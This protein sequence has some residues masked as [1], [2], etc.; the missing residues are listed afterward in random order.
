MSSDTGTG[1]HQ[2][3]GSAERATGEAPEPRRW[4]LPVLPGVLVVAL[5]E[6]CAHWFFPNFLP[7]P[8][9]IVLAAPNFVTDPT[10]S[11]EFFGSVAKTMLAVVE[12]IVIGV[13]LGVPAGLILG[14]NTVV[15]WFGE[16]YV[17]ALNAMPVVAIIPLSTLWLGYSNNMRLAVTAL[18][19]YLP[20]TLNVMDGTKHL[21]S[22]YLDVARS[23]RAGR[24][25]MWF[26]VA[27]P[28]ATPYLISGVQIAAGRAM[29]TG[30][31][32]EMIAAIQ[33]LGFFVIFQAR[34]F[35]HDEAFVG[36]LV[37][38]TFGILLLRVIKWATDRLVPWY[39]P[40]TEA[41]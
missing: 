25:R 26:D 12:G 15:R 38:A 10:L 13:V 6:V 9:R 34:S 1:V 4:W 21:P 18:S 30:I 31:T 22:T 29:V 27:V 11:S 17:H 20:I 36:V 2:D 40:D 39:R 5:W 41:G 16:R 7:R 24:L 19:A 37:I 8:S 35:N 33:G 14:R 3:V 28:A 23:F 32:S